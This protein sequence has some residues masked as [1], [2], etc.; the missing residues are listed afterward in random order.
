MVVTSPGT[1]RQT[2]RQRQRQTETDRQRQ[3]EGKGKR[4]RNGWRER[5]R[6][7][8]MP[9]KTARFEGAR[10]CRQILVRILLIG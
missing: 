1:K 9:A 7:R 3:R 4:G 6:A 10:P 2:D 8:K 5:G